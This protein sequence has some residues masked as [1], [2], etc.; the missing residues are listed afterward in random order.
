[1]AW[2][3]VKNTVMFGF[4]IYSGVTSQYLILA[5][6][7]ILELEINVMLGFCLSFFFFK[8]E[9]PAEKRSGGSTLKN[10]SR[11]SYGSFPAQCYL[12][13]QK[14][15]KKT[16]VYANKVSHKSTWEGVHNTYKTEMFP[17]AHTASVS[18]I[19]PTPA[20]IPVCQ[21]VLMNME[22]AEEPKCNEK[23]KS[24]NIAFSLEW[25]HD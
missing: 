11:I 3:K 2:P 5:I 4:K 16:A 21:L 1:M 12:L 17:H 22:L 15:G 10:K 23:K 13:L 14:W 18:W 9:E 24:I 25:M 19:N 8:F 6:Q 7:V 20:S